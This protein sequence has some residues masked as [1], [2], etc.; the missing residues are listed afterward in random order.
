MSWTLVGQS[1]ITRGTT[2]L[3]LRPF[4]PCSQI[5]PFPLFHLAGD[6]IDNAGA[7]GVKPVFLN[8]LVEALGVILEGNKGFDE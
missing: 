7:V 5:F 6:R 8:V 2:V 4:F 3:I 1:N